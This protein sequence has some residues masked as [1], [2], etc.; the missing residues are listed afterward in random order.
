VPVLEIFPAA[1]RRMKAASLNSFGVIVSAVVGGGR[2]SDTALPLTAIPALMPVTETRASPR[3]VAN[4]F[5]SN[6]CLDYKLISDS[7]QKQVCL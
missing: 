1:R 4:Y 7:G 6:N 3:E 2:L 5:C